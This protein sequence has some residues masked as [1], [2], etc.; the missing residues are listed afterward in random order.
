MRGGVTSGEPRGCLASRWSYTLDGL[1]DFQTVNMR[2]PRAGVTVIILSNDLSNDL[3][4]TAVRAA[5]LVFHIRLPRSRPLVDTPV[6][7]GAPTTALC[8]SPDLMPAHDPGMSGW[9]GQTVT[10]VLGK[11]VATTGA[12]NEYY[13][14]TPG[15]TMT[16]LGYP[17]DNTSSYCSTLPSETPPTG[18]YRWTLHRR[19]LTIKRVRFDTCPDRGA[20][21]PGVWTKVS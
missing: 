1:K 4:D 18:Y 15:G 5:A 19:T 17:L 8:C 12:G 7:S 3:W 13:Q 21:V 16:F 9:V 10:L 20:F 11:R 2:F 14:A 6:G